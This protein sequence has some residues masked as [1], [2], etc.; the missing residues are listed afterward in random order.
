MSTVSWKPADSPTLTTS[1][2]VDG[3]KE[4]I[5]W[6]VSEL[7]AVVQEQM[8]DDAGDK[9]LHSGLRLGESCL[10]VS[11]PS[12]AMNCL[13]NADS[14]RLYLYVPDVDAAY[15]H[16]TAAGAKSVT[17][18][19]D[20]FWGDRSARI[21]DPFGVHWTIGTHIKDMTPAEIHQAAKAWMGKQKT[22]CEG[23]KAK[24]E[25]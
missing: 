1:L 16:I 2:I 17:P 7:G 15:K 22:E 6:Y 14:T 5:A 4:A 9:V 21:I 3:A 24:D 12:A 8:L 10:F 13:A 18:P 25:L 11:D 23:Y 20:E 19:K